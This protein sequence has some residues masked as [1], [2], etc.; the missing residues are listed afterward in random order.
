MLRRCIVMLLLL[1]FLLS[2]AGLA[3]PP[4]AKQTADENENKRPAKESENKLPAEENDYELYRL[5]VDSIDQ[6]QENYVQHIDRRELIEAAIHGVMEK[7]DPYSS[8]IGPNDIDQLRTAV[9]SEFGGIGIQVTL[10]GG[11]LKI[12]SPIYGTPAYKAGL[13]AGDKIVEING[14]STDNLTP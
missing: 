1:P 8:Y 14:K 4:Q 2:G 13:L 11:E 7:L 12:L 6:V 9:E 3:A 10:D 5:L